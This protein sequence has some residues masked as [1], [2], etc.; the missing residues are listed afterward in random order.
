MQ[1]T[2]KRYHS[3]AFKKHPSIFLYIFATHKQIIGQ[4]ENNFNDTAVR[5]V[6]FAC[7]YMH[8]CL[9]SIPPYFHFSRKYII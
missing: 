6:L 5:I 2:K 3:D 7:A 4:K 8:A 1:P 9:S